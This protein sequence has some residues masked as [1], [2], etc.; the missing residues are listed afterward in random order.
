MPDFAMHIGAFVLGTLMVDVIPT[1]KN[2]A[3]R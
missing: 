1:V 3:E 2:R